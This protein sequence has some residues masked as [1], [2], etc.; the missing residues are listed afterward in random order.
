LADQ[1]GFAGL[2]GLAGLA[3]PA[4]QTLDKINKIMPRIA[5]KTHFFEKYSLNFHSKI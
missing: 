4:G 2:A 3:S 1:V 5:G